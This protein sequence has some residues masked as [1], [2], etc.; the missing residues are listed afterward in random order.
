MTR[1]LDANSSTLLA[2]LSAKGHEFTGEVQRATQSAVSAIES[3][4]FDFTR[5]MLDNSNELARLI[6]DA[7]ETATGRVNQ[8]MQNLQYTTREAI[9]QS[10]RIAAEVDHAGG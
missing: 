1:V 10:Q 9:E 8:T 6:N 4:G 7:G 3:K 5:T 2:A